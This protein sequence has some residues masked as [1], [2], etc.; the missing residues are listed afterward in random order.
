MLV[1]PCT[2]LLTVDG[3]CKRTSRSEV[4]EQDDLFRRENGRG[5]GHEVNTAE[6]DDFRRRARRLP[7]EAERVAD[8][9][10]DVLY[11]RPLVVVREDDGVAFLGQRTDLGLEILAHWRERMRGG[12]KALGAPSPENVLPHPRP[13]RLGKIR[14]KVAAA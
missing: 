8:E 9:V 3:R 4:G 2:Q 10:G 1:L 6:D 11:L 14:P 5:L 7:R 12:V 13:L